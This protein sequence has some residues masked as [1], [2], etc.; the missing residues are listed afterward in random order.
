MAT[1]FKRAIIESKIT[2]YQ[3]LGNTHVDGQPVTVNDLNDYHNLDSSTTPDAA[4][5]FAG[6]LAMTGSAV[7][8]DLLDAQVDT[9]GNTITTSAQKLRAVKFRNPS[10]NT[11]N[12]TITAGASNGN[13]F[14]GTGGSII[15]TPGS[16]MLLY[17]EN[18]GVTIDA[19]HCNI[20]ATGTNAEYLDYIFIYG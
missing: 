3:E 13:L 8:I 12:I 9:E 10:T 2:V 7:T 16:H 14:L 11:G 17:L 20:D 18:D 19:T 6:H 15:L 4:Y 5:A 1:T